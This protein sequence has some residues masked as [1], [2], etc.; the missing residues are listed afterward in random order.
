MKGIFLLITFFIFV[1]TASSQ[2]LAKIGNITD[3]N[4]FIW[5]GSGEL[6]QD[7]NLC[8]FSET[9]KYKVTV[10]GNN[11][12]F[13]LTDNDLSIPYSIKWNDVA[14]NTNNV[15]LSNNIPLTNQTGA[16]NVDED[17]EGGTNANIEIS[18]SESDLETSPAGSY[19]GYI[20]IIVEAIN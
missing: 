14:N 12:G 11:S 9:G 13:F 20:T 6:I 5:S 18:F 17:C 8:V 7:S 1:N 15:S 19:T 16:S 10:E 2:N 3:F 4:S